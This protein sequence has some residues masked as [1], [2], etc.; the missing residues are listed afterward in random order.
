MFPNTVPVI[1]PVTPWRYRTLPLARGPHPVP[2]QSPVY[3]RQ[4]INS[5]SS[6]RVQGP[7]IINICSH[8][9]PWCFVLCRIYIIHIWTI[10]PAQPE[11]NL[12]QGGLRAYLTHPT[13]P[14]INVA[15]MGNRNY[16]ATCAGI[17]PF[18]PL[19]SV[20]IPALTHP[21]I[22][23]EGPMFAQKDWNSGHLYLISDPSALGAIYEPGPHS[24]AHA[25]TQTLHDVTDLPSYIV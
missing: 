23:V 4:S 20:P 21:L 14:P 22:L 8:T 7:N 17:I 13:R 2:Q 9:V 25:W 16:T 18:S 24:V 1:V 6:K 5:L 3:V 10:F 19:H 12:D 15:H 11:I